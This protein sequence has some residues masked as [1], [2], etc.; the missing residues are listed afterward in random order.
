M[1]RWLQR[2]VPTY[3]PVGD[4]RQPIQFR[5]DADGSL[6]LCT[7]QGQN[8]PYICT[9]G[10]WAD[11][12]SSAVLPS[13]SYNTSVSGDGNIIIFGANNSNCYIRTAGTWALSKTGLSGGN[14]T[15]YDGAKTIMHASGSGRLWFRT[16]TTWAETQPAG[17]ANVN[18]YYT[19]MSG[20][21]T[22]AMVTNGSWFG[23]RLYTWESSVWTI[24]SFGHGGT[25]PGFWLGISS[26]SDGSVRTA[27]QAI[28]PSYVLYPW[29]Y[30]G[31]SWAEESI[32]GITASYNADMMVSA[33]GS[34]I[35]FMQDGKL[36]FKEGGTWSAGQYIGTTSSYLYSI[37]A[38]G[39]K[40]YFGSY[41]YRW[42]IWCARPSTLSAMPG[43]RS[44]P[45]YT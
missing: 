14:A 21:G 38:D 7:A 40:V 44:V 5:T 45:V 27:L 26:S 33:D 20:D 30:S 12:P 39:S 17:A 32:P 42:G 16:G 31:G 11:K 1:A 29:V 35:V 25:L 41:Y 23:S 15:S 19:A 37:N 9:N 22:V 10:V 3:G 34:T 43:G 18:W 24:N 8:S 4:V 2:I 6:L 28:T 13:G 36:Y